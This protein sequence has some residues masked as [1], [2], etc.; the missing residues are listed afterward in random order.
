MV[1]A[2]IYSHWVSQD[3][4]EQRASLIIGEGYR[5]LA[6][7]HANSEEPNAEQYA[8]EWRNLQSSVLNGLREE[9]KQFK[10]RKLEGLADDCGLD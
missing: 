6:V 7:T 5:G 8:Q 1:E 4:G 10:A 3:Q 9:F 2:F